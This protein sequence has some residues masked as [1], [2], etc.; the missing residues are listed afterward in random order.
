MVTCRTEKT[1]V[2]QALAAGVSDFIPKPIGMDE[3][4]SRVNFILNSDQTS[5]MTGT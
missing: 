5:S 4:V 3:L 2:R 1:A